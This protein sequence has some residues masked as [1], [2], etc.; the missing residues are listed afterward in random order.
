MGQ[1]PTF[2]QIVLKQLDIVMKKNVL[3][4][5]LTAYTKLFWNES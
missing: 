5:H 4:T 2:Q 1:G 3:N